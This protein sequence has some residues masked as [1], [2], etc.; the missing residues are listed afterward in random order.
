MFDMNFF[1]KTSVSTNDIKTCQ[2]S[3]IFQ[4]AG[5]A[6]LQT[7]TFFSLLDVFFNVCIEK[8]GRKQGISEGD[9]SRY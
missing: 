6:N 5:M 8:S 1:K 9:M 4:I 7:S 2:F 3:G